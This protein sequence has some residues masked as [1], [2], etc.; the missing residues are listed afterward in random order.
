MKLASSLCGVGLAACGFGRSS[1]IIVQVSGRLKS[2]ELIGRQA[3]VGT[4]PLRVDGDFL[5]FTKIS[6]GGQDFEVLVD[7]GRCAVLSQSSSCLCSSSLPVPIYGS[8]LQ[9]K[10]SHPRILVVQAPLS[11]PSEKQMVSL[12]NN[13]GRHTEPL[14]GPVKFADLVLAGYT[15][16]NQAYRRS[17]SPNGIKLKRTI[18]LCSGA[19]ES[20]PLESS[21]ST[22]L[23]RAR[24]W[25]QFSHLSRFE[26]K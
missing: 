6:L 25:G 15:V 23:H 1:A 13:A 19:P 22:R 2:A 5:H 17:L 12:L 21:G 14:S 26:Q 18:Y 24:S 11:M 4:T 8:E 9:L 10:P 20:Q 16:R 7:T 3:L